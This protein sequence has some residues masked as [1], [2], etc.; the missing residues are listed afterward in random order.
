MRK[1][2]GLVAMLAMALPTFAAEPTDALAEL[3]A[4]RAKR[5]LFAYERDE[6]LTQAAAACATYR[7]D[8]LM[9]GHTGND[10]AF[11]PAGAHADAAGCA[12]WADG[13]GA[14]CMHATEY[15]TAGAAYV[16]GRNGLRFCQLFVRRGPP[17]QP[18]GFTPPLGASGPVA[19]KSID[20]KAEVGKPA[21]SGPAPTS[22]TITC[23]RMKADPKGVRLP[24]IEG[25]WSPDV[26]YTE[27]AP[28]WLAAGGSC[29]SGQCAAPTASRMPYTI[30]GSCQ[31]GNCPKK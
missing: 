10:F 23:T 2:L 9:S 25:T 3:N 11:L 26:T 24:G 30:Q 18:V 6:G 19:P 1:V 16:V 28:A 22:G 15:R 12:A 4:D 27:P 14:C 29:P 13:F 5:G 21:A 20:L 17:T 8:R 31:N 7:A